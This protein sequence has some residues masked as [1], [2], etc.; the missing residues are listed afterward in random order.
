MS[1]RIF[2]VFALILL[3]GMVQQAYA[4]YWF[5]FGARGGTESSYNNGSSIEIQTVL[6]NVSFG[7]IAFWTGE[8]LRNGAFLQVG[9][10]IENQT[11]YYPSLCSFSGCS[12]NEII[13][14]GNAEWFYEYFPPNQNSGGF[15][16]KVGP[17]GSGGEN[18]TINT[19]AFYSVGPVWYFTVNGV[20][21]GNASLGSA[22]SGSN[23]PVAF[24]EVAN[25]SI[26]TEFIKR[27]MMENFSVYKSKTILPL[28]SG[29]AYVGYGQG[30][31]TA[32][33]TPYGIEEL[34]NRSNMF[35]LGSGLA[36]E[37]NGTALW[38]HGYY[39]NIISQYGGISGRF[40]YSPDVNAHLPYPP[41][42]VNISNGTHAVFGGWDGTGYGSYTGPQNEGVVMMYENI[43]EN[44]LWNVYYLLNISGTYGQGFGGG[45][46]EKGSIVQY[47]INSST[48]YINS[49][50]RLI[51]AGWSNGNPNM[52]GYVTLENATHIHPIWKREF[53]VGVDSNMSSARGSGWY[54]YGEEI[55]ASISSMMYNVSSVERYVFENWSTGARTPNTNFTVYGPIRIKA[56]FQK[57]YLISIRAVGNDSSSINASGYEIGNVFVTNDV[58][59]NSSSTYTVEKA[60]YR[61]V[62]ITVNR[63]FEVIAPSI[64]QVMLP[65]YNVRIRTFDIFGLP[66]NSLVYIT[67]LNG[68]SEQIYTGSNG[69]AEIQNVPYGYL[70]GSA[71]YLFITQNLPKNSTGKITLYFIQMLDIAAII[72]A[73][74]VAS[75]IYIKIFKRARR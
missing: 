5:Q 31:L 36:R 25:T 24:G 72:F 63:T 55:S 61:G 38:K 14:A 42:I 4:Q 16:G 37:P 41:N 65:V 20:V 19:Y 59:L 46:H 22:G 39:L 62:F 70:N 32:L 47:G 23:I 15:L 71:E 45:W 56:D 51:F 67:M 52:S 26:N 35:V 57:Q 27:V 1:T 12:A 68:T 2:G 18:G 8:D 50:Y 9:Y 73:A 53:F 34:N 60:E 75:V 7:S 44:A 17:D 21:V 29:Y 30:S 40:G 64:I 74:V 33:N 49:T 28:P 3:L 13:H 58:F 10:V 66:V 11:G 43:T 54:T 48:V 6:Q 69:S